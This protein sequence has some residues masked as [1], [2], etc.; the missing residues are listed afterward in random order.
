MSAPH[1]R[2]TPA[3][4]RVSLGMPVF[5]GERYLEEALRSLLAQT[6][7]DFELL[8]YDNA[9][10]DRTRTICL[11]YAARDARIRYRR[12]AE[13]VGFVR[14]QNAVIEDARGKYFLLTHHD[15]VR[16]PTYLERTIEVLD[17]DDGVTVCYTVTRDIDEHGRF[18]PR[19]DPVLRLAS[20]DPRERFRD[21]IRMDHLCEADFGLTR[22][23]ALRQ[24]RLHG[25]YA[26][27]DRV[28]L[29]ELLL[30]GR[31][32]RIPECLF[33]RRAHALQST[34]I[35]PDRQGRTVWFDPAVRDRLVF[36][37]FREF[38]EYL[39]AI[40]R[41]PVGLG[42]RLSCYAAMVRWLGTN[43]RRLISD[44]DFAGRQLLRPLKRAAMR[45][46]GRLR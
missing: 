16:L 21:V 46:S 41:A 43:R 36:P 42:T 35:A 11:D 24:T 40:G 6:F 18:L 2:R 4:P 3:T 26:D 10:A 44:V 29:A 20:D 23:D 31:F 17:A 19:E 32:H 45:R 38:R 5:N 25:A 37:H 30:R 39:A 34:A 14:N 28:L 12:N 8:V 33:H 13:N 1:P 27:S 9:S 7:E 15:D 22:L